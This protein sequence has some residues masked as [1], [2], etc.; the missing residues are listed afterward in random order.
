MK[1]NKAVHYKSSIL[2]FLQ[3]CLIATNDLYLRNRQYT[4]LFCPMI[5]MTRHQTTTGVFSER[6]TPWLLR[7]SWSHCPSLCVGL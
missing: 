1:Q 7:M 4:H 6:L 5:L 2:H 3:L